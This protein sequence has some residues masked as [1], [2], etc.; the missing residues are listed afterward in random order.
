MNMHAVGLHVECHIRHVQE[1]ISEIFLDQVAL[2]AAANYEITNS[3]VGINFHDVPENRP[4]ANFHHWLRAQRGLLAQACT[5]TSGKNDCFHKEFDS[6][7][8]SWLHSTQ[9]RRRKIGALEAQLP[10]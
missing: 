3:I 1:I 2:V 6:Q 7:R 10:A 5:K 8:F 9:K 4:A